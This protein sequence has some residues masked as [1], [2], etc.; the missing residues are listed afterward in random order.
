MLLLQRP[1]MFFHAPTV[2]D[3]AHYCDYTSDCFRVICVR[4]NLDRKPRAIFA[5]SL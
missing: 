2:G 3:V 1:E 4:D 5:F